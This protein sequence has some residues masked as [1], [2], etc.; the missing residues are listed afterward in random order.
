MDF[1]AGNGHLNVVKWLHKNRKEGCTT[2]AMDLA[3]LNEHIDIVMWLNENR[4]E[5]S[6]NFKILHCQT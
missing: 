6:S 2:T 1:A 3:M 5:D 4:K